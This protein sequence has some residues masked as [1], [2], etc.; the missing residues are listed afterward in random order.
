MRL[1]HWP[2]GS[3]KNKALRASRE[4]TSLRV[5]VSKIAS[6]LTANESVVIEESWV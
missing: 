2:G 3:E 1:M 4:I 5:N 6:G